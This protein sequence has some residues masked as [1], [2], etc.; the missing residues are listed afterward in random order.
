M[1]GVKESIHGLQIP[2]RYDLTCSQLQEIVGARAEADAEK[3]DGWFLST[4]IGMAFKYGYVQGLK[5]GK[6]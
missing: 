1:K 4:V 3:G 6:K 5:A 2:V